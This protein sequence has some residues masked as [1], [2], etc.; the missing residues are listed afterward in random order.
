MMDSAIIFTFTRAAPG[1]EDKAFQAFTES[2]AFFGT[3][4]HEGKCG[5]PINV[6]GTS[7]M[8]LMIIPGEY[9]ALSK[10]LRTD[11]FRELFTKTVF[12][13]PDVSYQMGAYGQGVQDLMARWARVGSGP[14]RVC[15]HPTASTSSRRVYP[16]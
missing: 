11:D 5:E 2:M 12:A 4:A 8:G 9:D 14:R 3:A 6:S 15:A 16:R 7:G 1:R 10:L 13:V